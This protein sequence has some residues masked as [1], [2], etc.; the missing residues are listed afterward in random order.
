LS[1]CTNDDDV[2]DDDD[3]DSKASTSSSTHNEEQSL[4][5][6]FGIS[7][8]YLDGRQLSAEAVC[9][10]EPRPKSLQST[11]FIRRSEI[12]RGASAT[13]RESAAD[14]S[15]HPVRLPSTND[16]HWPLLTAVV[17]RAEP[18]ALDGRVVGS[19]FPGRC[20]AKPGGGPHTSYAAVFVPLLRTA[21]TTTSAI[22][23]SDEP[24]DLSVRTGA[25]H[26]T[27]VD[28]STTQTITTDGHFQRAELT[29]KLYRK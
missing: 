5:R 10:A 18:T 21:T 11:T 7:V 9:L 6:S 22:D 26:V 15:A 27:V 16:A 20:L 3:D 1:D 23:A 14:R 29:G 13:G 28:N 19:N 25:R 17:R 4:M 8:G 12:V 24:E 2:D